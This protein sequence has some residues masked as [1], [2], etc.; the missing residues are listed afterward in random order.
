MTISYFLP[1]D[2]G[3]QQQVQTTQAG[4][5]LTCAACGTQLEV[6]TLRRL[7]ELEIVV[8]EN[9]SRTVASS[10]TPVQGT[11]F[12]VGSVIAIVS[13][14]AILFFTVSDRKLSAKATVLQN[15][16]LVLENLAD[17]TPEES[18]LEWQTLQN[19]PPKR[20]PLH[21]QQAINWK[22]YRNIAASL[23]LA[24]TVLAGLALI[25]GR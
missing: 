22:F 12:L 14:A 9:S 21:N 24:G 19:L 17:L 5:S 2:C 6:P 16:Q 10:W 20:L 8:G 4:E 11:M 18:W 25:V 15:K 1:C 23:C 3:T 7:R 13:F